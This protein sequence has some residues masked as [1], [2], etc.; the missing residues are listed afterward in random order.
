MFQYLEQN[1]IPFIFCLEY[2][3]IDVKSD[4]YQELQSVPYATS[5][6]VCRDHYKLLSF[7]NHH[8]CASD[9]L[10]RILKIFKKHKTTCIGFGKDAFSIMCVW[11]NEIYQVPREKIYMEIWYKDQH[12]YTDIRM[13]CGVPKC[14]KTIFWAKIKA[15]YKLQWYNLLKKYMHKSHAFKVAACI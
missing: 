7:N 8:V 3:V 4:L 10:K 6:T 14:S 11:K 12:C 15:L 2:D 1:P 9:V 5:A 13:E